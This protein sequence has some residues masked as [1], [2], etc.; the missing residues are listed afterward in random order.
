MDDEEVNLIE[1]A[2]DLVIDL[3]ISNKITGDKKQKA[4][5]AIDLLAQVIKK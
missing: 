4:L 1:V 2:I 3:I 5:D